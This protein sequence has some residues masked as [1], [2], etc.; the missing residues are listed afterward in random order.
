[1]IVE[2]FAGDS[3]AEN[4]NPVGRFYYGFSTVST[5]GSL[6]QPGGWARHPGRPGR[7]AEGLM[8]AGFA[9]VRGGRVAAEHRARGA[10]ALNA[11]RARRHVPPR[12]YQRTHSCSSSATHE[13]VVLVIAH[14]VGQE[15][16]RATVDGAERRAPPRRGTRRRPSSAR[17]A[18]GPRA[19]SAASTR[20][21]EAAVAEAREVVGRR[22]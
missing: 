9:S 2:P 5:P 13:R 1:M 16:D 20:R 7:L 19:A 8:A 11:L 10:P 3:V 12:A 22:R 21:I 15:H 4:L 17:P 14:P 6:S 18:S